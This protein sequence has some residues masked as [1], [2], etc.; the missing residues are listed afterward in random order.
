MVEPAFC[1]LPRSNTSLVAQMVNNL[2]AMQETQVQSLCWKYLL[3]E[4]MAVAPVFLPREFHRQ[5]SLVKYS[6]QGH[7]ELDMTK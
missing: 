7:K 1:A 4:D 5:R 3:E 6:L 2:P